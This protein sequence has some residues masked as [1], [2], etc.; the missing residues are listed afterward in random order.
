MRAQR[1][2]FAAD[3]RNLHPVDDRLDAHHIVAD[4]PEY[5]IVVGLGRVL[6]QSDDSLWSVGLLRLI[7]VGHLSDAARHSLGC[8]F[9]GLAG[10]DIDELMQIV[11]SG[12]A[13]IKGMR[14]N[15][16]AGSIAAFKRSAKQLRLLCQSDVRNQSRSCYVP[17][18]S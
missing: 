1:D 4:Q 15:R 10:V 16:I 2:A 17:I 14:R 9:E 11:L 12:N 8:Q 6:A 18:S 7:G 13:S 5:A 3:E